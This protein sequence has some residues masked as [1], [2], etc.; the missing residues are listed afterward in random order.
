MFTKPALVTLFINS[1]KHELSSDLVESAARGYS[2]QVC[3]YR[4]LVVIGEGDVPSRVEPQPVGEGGTLLFS[5]ILS[6]LA[7][8]RDSDL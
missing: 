7:P 3:I 1:T 2:H 8:V 5:P 4:L 6:S